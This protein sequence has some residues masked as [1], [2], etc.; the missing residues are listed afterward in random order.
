ME[1]PAKEE[2]LGKPTEQMLGMMGVFGMVYML[3]FVAVGT[4]IVV[5]LWRGMRAQEA[6]ARHWRA[7]GNC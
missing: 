3:S 7:C 6:M 5:S 1:I 4:V 2:A